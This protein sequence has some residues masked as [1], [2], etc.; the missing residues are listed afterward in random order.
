VTEIVRNREHGDGA[1]T[2]G[3]TGIRGWNVASADE[4][5]WM[6]VVDDVCEGPEGYIKTEARADELE[7]EIECTDDLID[8]IVYD[9]Y[10]LTDEEIGI[11]KE[12]VEE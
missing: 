3:R 10:G 6:P 7:A 12:A 11:V 2:I 1:P 8:E 9:L 4:H 5:V